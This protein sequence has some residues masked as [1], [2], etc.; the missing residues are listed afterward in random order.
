MPHPTG[1]TAPFL[2]RV[3]FT[4]HVNELVYAADIVYI[5]AESAQVSVI[6]TD[7]SIAMSLCMNQ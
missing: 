2:L 1:A 7:E 5:N 4:F 3:T 6:M